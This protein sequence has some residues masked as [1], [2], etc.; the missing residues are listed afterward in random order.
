[1]EIELI[2]SVQESLRRTIEQAMNQFRDLESCLKRLH[3]DSTDK[4]SAIGKDNTAYNLN[5][6]SEYLGYH[7][8]AVEYDTN[9]VSPPEWEAFSENNISRAKN[10]RH[11]SENLRRKIQE[12]LA[13]SFQQLNAQNA[14]VQL[15]FSKRINETTNAKRKLELQHRKITGEIQSMQDSIDMLEKQFCDLQMHLKVNNTRLEHRAWR[16]NIELCRDEPKHGLVSEYHTITG[17]IAAVK[18]RLSDARNALDRLNNR[19][20]ELEQ[21]INVKTFTLFIDKDQ[22]G[23]LRRQVDWRPFIQRNSGA[24]LSLPYRPASRLASPLKNVHTYTP[25]K[26]SIDN[27]PSSK[28]GIKGELLT[29]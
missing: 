2:S 1:M 17:D 28:L 6:S 7:K 10:S 29:Y 19:K 22:C 3:K 20:W 26:L 4:T 14:A 12:L 9:A 18:R 15:A 8:H 27:M 23:K 21:E 5:N 16:P 25:Q 24:V 13:N 11:C